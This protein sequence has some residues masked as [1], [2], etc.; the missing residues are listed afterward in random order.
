MIIQSYILLNHQV[1]TLFH[2]ILKV[3]YA[4]KE[5]FIVLSGTPETKGIIYIKL[6]G[7]SVRIKRVNAW[8]NISSGSTTL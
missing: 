6:K 3:Q 4:V 8:Y 1:Q 2:K 7:L 5:S